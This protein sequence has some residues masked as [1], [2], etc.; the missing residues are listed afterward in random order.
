MEKRVS[1]TAK[2]SAFVRSFHSDKFLSRGELYNDPLAEK[3]LN[4]EIMK[5]WESIAANADWLCE[6]RGEGCEDPVLYG[7]NRRLAPAVLARAIWWEQE[8]RRE[9]KMG[10]RQILLLGAGL[11]SLPYRQ[12]GEMEKAKYYEVDMPEM[13]AYKE[14]QLE[15]E[16]ITMPEN[17]YRLGADLAENWIEPLLWQTPFAPE[18]R[19]LTVML[20]VAYYLPQKVLDKLLAQLADITPRGSTLLFDCQ[21]AGF[22][23]SGGTDTRQRELAAA[24]GEAMTDGMSMVEMALMLE[25]HGY[26]I[27]ED[28]DETQI[29]EHFY[30]E[31][32]E[33]NPPYAIHPMPHTAMILAVR[34]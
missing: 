4:G 18:E 28:M 20:G 32:N 29:E 14:L 17:V 21:L 6:G 26:L 23:E 1:M 3:M 10:T 13:I 31:Y 7:I 12:T 34:Y 19:S 33:K 16:K 8:L 11:D 25:R 24:A 30:R 5:I 9:L 22:G 2:M 27:Y 15:K